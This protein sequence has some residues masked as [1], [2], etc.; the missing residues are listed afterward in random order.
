MANGYVGKVLWVNLANGLIEEEVIPEKIYREFLG[1]NGLGIRLLYERMKACVDPLGPDNILGFVPGLLTASPVPATGRFIVV[2]KSPL[3]GGW[4]ESNSGGTFAPELK[5]AGYDAV[6]FTGISAQPVYLLLK[7]GKASLRDASH[8]WGKDTHETE[9]CLHQE[10]SDPKV[11]IASIGPAG[12]MQSLVAGIV[13][14]KGRIAA[15][16]GVGAVM[17]SK[18]LKAV[19]IRGGVHKV[20]VGAPDKLKVARQRFQENLK[21]SDFAKGLSAGGTAGG[22]SFLVS[23]GDSPVRNWKLSGVGALPAV[24]N[25]DSAEMEGMKISDYG[26]Y[27]CPIRC[28]AIIEQKEGPHAVPEELHRPEYESL[29]GL[30]QLLMNDN[31]KIAIKANDLCNRY[32]IDTITVGT[33]IALAMECYE[34][35]LITRDDTGGIELTWGNGDAIL[36]MVEKIGKREGF[37]AILADGVQHAAERIGKGAEKYAVAIRGKG[38]PFHDPRMGPALGTAMIS[39]ANPAHHMDSSI[40]GM[41][42]NGLSVGTDPALQTPRVPF[43]AFSQK[44]PL[45]ALGSAYHQLLN[46]AG[47]C[48]LFTV[49]MLPPPAAELIAGVTG[50]DF[51]WEEA[52]KVGR[53]ILTLRQAFNA[54]EGLTPDQFELPKRL[55]EEPLTTGPLANTKID[56]DAL[57]KGYFVAMGWNLGSGKPN[58]VTLGA[59]GLAEIAR[60]IVAS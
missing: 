17:G 7:D 30:G 27:A 50:W 41:L 13:N 49:N 23:I 47:F 31:L 51:G 21:N 16:N 20:R 32:G 55:K 46:A 40:T 18:R 44:G 54:R 12:E 9:D 57:K 11:K 19:A 59:L 53:R 48:A 5:T 38:L 22:L 1:G 28:G 34:H 10:L 43:D 26:C 4:G 36:A 60:D 25:L 52:L 15:R 24:S 56:F 6:F 14:E 8:L 39:D 29:A 33:T 45:Y 35:G 58:I 3:T 37:G 2:T 42:E